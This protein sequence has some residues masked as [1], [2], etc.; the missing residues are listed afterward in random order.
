MNADSMNDA[1]LVTSF[2]YCALIVH[3]ASLAPVMGFLDVVV[4]IY[5]YIFVTRLQASQ[6]I[7]EASP[8]A[9]DERLRTVLDTFTA[10]LMAI[11]TDVF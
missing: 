11:R 3:A 1:L 4:T 6:S 10:A 2:Y 5:L 7:T 9:R 8:K